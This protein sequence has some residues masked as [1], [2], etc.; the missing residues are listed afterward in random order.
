MEH[1]PLG[2]L[3]PEL[4]N[5]I[6]KLVLCPPQGL[7]IHLASPELKI[8][9]DSGY[10]TALKQ[11]CKQVFNESKGYLFADNRVSFEKPDLDKVTREAYLQ[12][13]DILQEWLLTVY[14]RSGA[15]PTSKSASRYFM[16][17]S[18]NLR[19]TVQGLNRHAVAKMMAITER[20]QLEGHRP[21][22]HTVDFQVISSNL[23][24]DLETFHVPLSA[25]Q[26]KS[27]AK[28]SVINSAISQKQVEIDEALESGTVN[29]Q[30]HA[31]IRRK[32]YQ[33]PKILE[34]FTL[35]VGDGRMTK[36]AMKIDCY[37]KF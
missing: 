36:A 5:E 19:M 8:L 30:R 20:Y 27:K 35:A 29:K 24:S 17:S 12:W 18:S 6:Y 28:Q 16:F 11:T 4:R 10:S 25:L 32:L 1:S 14:K 21:V 9:P 33:C 15:T 23:K 31:Y 26:P 22:K 13:D 37:I 7:R 34:K 3:A 2:K